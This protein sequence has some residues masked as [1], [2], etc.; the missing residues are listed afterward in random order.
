MTIFAFGRKAL[1]VVFSAFKRLPHILTRLD[2]RSDD[3]KTP[4]P[5]LTGDDLKKRTETSMEFAPLLKRQHGDGEEVSRFR[6]PGPDI[7]LLFPGWYC[8]PA[9][10]TAWKRQSQNSKGRNT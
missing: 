3:K 7:G 8:I 4:L 9:D 6:R 2:S 10:D 1:Q 5:C